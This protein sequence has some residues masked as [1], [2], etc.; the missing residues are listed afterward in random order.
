MINQIRAIDGVLVACSFE[1]LPNNQVRIS[2]RSKSDV[3]DVSS[4]AQQ[5]GG[6]GHAR[7]AGIRLEGPLEVAREKVITAV[8]KLVT[9]AGL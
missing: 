2:L 8:Q 7:A 1:D 6:G 3:L 9:E 5:Y 4:V